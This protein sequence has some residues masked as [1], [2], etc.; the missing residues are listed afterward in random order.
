VRLALICALFAGCAVVLGWRLYTFQV[1]D[2][3]R[4]QKLAE[5]ERHGTIP[6]AAV[7]GALL[8]TSGA[9]LAV[10]VRYDSVYVLGTL[11]GG[12]DKADK[13]AATLSSILGVPAAELRAQIDPKNDHGVVLKSRVP[14]SVAQQVQTLSLPGV[15][16]DKEPMRQYPEG[17]LAAQIL[18][19]VG[20][21][22]NGLGGLELSFDAELAGTPGAIDTQKDTAGQEIARSIATC[23]VW[24][25]DC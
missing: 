24:P 1:V 5:A 17:S 25:R 23:S 9:P 12:S 18:G 13:L 14:S 8:D 4:Y 19:F 7:R 15:Y 16:M 2:V 3:A 10:T 22:F 21:D 20:R 11:V 6:I